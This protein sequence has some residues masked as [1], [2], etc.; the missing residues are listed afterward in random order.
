MNIS[1][2]KPKSI[3]GVI[4]IGVSPFTR[5]LFNNVRWAWIWLI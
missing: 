1:H 5:A 2:V 4:S 3:K